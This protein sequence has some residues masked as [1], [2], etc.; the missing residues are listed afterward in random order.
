MEQKLISEPSFQ[1]KNFR[2]ETLNAT[3]QSKS[4]HLEIQAKK[5]SQFKTINNS[6]EIFISS[7]KK[8]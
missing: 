2:D 4:Y 6:K 1:S 7:K 5:G 3:S 8:I